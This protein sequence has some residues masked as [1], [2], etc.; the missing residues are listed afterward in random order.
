MAGHS[1]F[2]NNLIKHVALGNTAFKKIALGNDIVWSGA[3]LVSYYD[4]AT[5]LGTEEV[6]EGEDVL[7]PLSITP[8]KTDYTFVGW[9]GYGGT[10]RFETK[11]ATGEP[12]S[13]YALFVPNTLVVAQGSMRSE[14]NSIYRG[15]NF[16]YTN[17]S[18]NT[19]YVTGAIVSN[20]SS[21]YQALVDTKTF[22]L[23]KRYYQ[24]ADLQLLFG[25]DGEA[26]GSCAFDGTH[27]THSLSVAVD[28]KT[29]NNI[30]NGNHTITSAIY[31]TGDLKECTIGIG[32]LTLSNPAK[33]A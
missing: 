10:E 27:I 22:T 24:R 11:V 8:T 14:Y 20:V 33:W 18:V 4:G 25:N 30:S 9:T 32:T 5:L 13:L 7:R 15:W 16:I 3:S 2:E 1:A 26:N 19:N 6:D 12:M 29:F 17:G 31:A 23:N 28:T 21:T